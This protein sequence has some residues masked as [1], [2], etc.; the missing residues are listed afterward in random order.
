MRLAGAGGEFGLGLSMEA[1]EG[2]AV[3]IIIVATK[4]DG[5]GQAVQPHVPLALRVFL[6]YKWTSHRGPF[7]A[8]RRSGGAEAKAAGT[9]GPSVGISTMGG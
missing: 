7:K 2:F 5:L 3:L 8:V 6:V 4:S 9:N 1:F